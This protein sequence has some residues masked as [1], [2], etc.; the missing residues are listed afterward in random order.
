MALL[1]LVLL[2][3]P[4]VAVTC[5]PPDMNPVQLVA[6]NLESPR[7]SYDL[8]VVGRVL[9]ITTD[10]SEGES[11]GR[12][13][14]EMSLVGVY[15]MSGVDGRGFVVTTPDPGWMSG[16]P[17]EE[18][19]D[20]FVPLVLS[21]SGGEA[22]VGACDLVHRVTDVDATAQELASVADESGLAYTF[23]IEE[24]VGGAAATVI[25]VVVMGGLLMWTGKRLRSN[26]RRLDETGPDEIRRF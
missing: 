15:G 3:A 17:F 2:A 5:A 12:T 7:N 26:R 23:P 13:Y 20:Y 22:H 6:A 21:D 18:G 24:R 14:V 8:A 11:H 16:Y 10:M 4:A 9:A 25:F 1:S 19:A